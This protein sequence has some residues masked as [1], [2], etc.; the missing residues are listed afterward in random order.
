M[1]WAIGIITLMAVMAAIISGGM[2]IRLMYI[3]TEYGRL[4]RSERESQTSAGIQ[5]GA[6]E[7]T[8]KPG[9]DGQPEPDTRRQILQDRK[10]LSDLY[11]KRESNRRGVLFDGACVVAILVD[12]FATALGASPS[13]HISAAVAFM[14]FSEALVLLHY[15]VQ[16]VLRLSQ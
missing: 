15:H 9:A 11:V 14:F 1:E 7:T 13:L 3:D 6:D 8:P 16:A 12:G 2:G 10:T 4:I 5:S